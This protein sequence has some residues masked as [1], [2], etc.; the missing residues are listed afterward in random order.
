MTTG[1]IFILCLNN[2]SSCDGK[3]STV[4]LTRG[5]VIIG[6]KKYDEVGMALQTQIIW[7]G[8]HKKQVCFDKYLDCEGNDI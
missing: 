4:V 1:E 6:Y 7:Y 8:L 5:N 3:L 2:L